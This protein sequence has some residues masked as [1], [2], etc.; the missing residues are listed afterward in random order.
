MTFRYLGSVRPAT[1]WAGI[2]IAAAGHAAWSAAACAV[3][4]IALILVAIGWS[5]ALAGLIVSMMMNPAGGSGTDRPIP[6][7]SAVIPSPLNGTASTAIV[8]AA[9]DPLPG[10]TSVDSEPD[11][12]AP[13]GEYKSPPRPLVP[14]FAT[15]YFD[16]AVG[17]FDPTTLGNT[18]PATNVAASPI[19]FDPAAGLFDT[20]TLDLN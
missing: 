17:L 20:R 9:A 18:T 4:R 3:R 7:I 2:Q 6:E 11:L 5:A 16:P 10:A 1:G 8:A 15:I 13:I 14:H 12:F 19:Y